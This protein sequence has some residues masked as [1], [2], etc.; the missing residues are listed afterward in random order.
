MPKALKNLSPEELKAK[1]IELN[2]LQSELYGFG[3]AGVANKNFDRIHKIAAQTRL[4]PDFGE[5]ILKDTI[6]HPNEEVQISAAF[7]LV[8]IDPS[9]ALRTFRKFL[10]HDSPWISTNAEVCISE[11]K[12]G[13]LNTNWFMEKFAPDVILPQAFLG[14]Q[15]SKKSYW[16]AFFTCLWR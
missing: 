6:K 11:W 4:L 16:L 2:V 9:L 14:A 15:E 8:P 12:A 7:L 3:K 13:K 10:N 1:F 5:A